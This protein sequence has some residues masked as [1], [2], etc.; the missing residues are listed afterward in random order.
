MDSPTN[1]GTKSAE[2]SVLC[3]TLPGVRLWRKN[4]LCSVPLP[5]ALWGPL[6]GVSRLASGG[7]TAAKSL[8]HVLR[9]LA[10][11][12]R[13]MDRPSSSSPQVPMQNCR[14]AVFSALML[15]ATQLQPFAAP[16][17]VD[18]SFDAGSTV[19]GAVNAMALQA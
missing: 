17:D 1:H 12:G 4:V 2:N 16:G 18:L 19:N 11:R 7:V 15:A 13:R 9:C 5:F 8:F 6:S 10:M 14:T 3:P